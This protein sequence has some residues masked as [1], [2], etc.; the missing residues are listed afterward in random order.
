MKLDVTTAA[1]AGRHGRRARRPVRH[2]AEHRGDAPGRHRAARAPPRRHAQHQDPRRGRRR[3][4][5]AVAPE[6]HRPRPP[7][8]DPRA[9][10]ARRR[11][12][13]RPQAARLLAA[14]PQEDGAPR[15]PLGAVRPRRRGPGA[16]SSTTG[17]STSRRPS[18][19]IAVLEALGLRTE[20]ERAAAGAPRPRPHRG[21]GVEV[22]PQ[23]RRPRAD[24]APRGAQRLRRARQRLLVFSDGARSTTAIER[25]SEPTP[26]RRWTSMSSP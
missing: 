3:R 9:A 4:R 23:P 10:V 18:T 12:R 19:G 5:E 21:R 1:G 7:G 11:H 24:R 2:R 6:G 14:H 16:W 17:A 20:G 15:A 25:Y 8:F 13:P 26:T 22:V